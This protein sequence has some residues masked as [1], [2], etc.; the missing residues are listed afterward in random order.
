MLELSNA[1]AEVDRAYHVAQ[2]TY[3]RR[4]A[5]K[6][7]VA[8]TKAAYESDKAPLDLYLEAQRRN[9][10]AESEF[11]RRPG[12]IRPGDQEL[13]ITRKARC[14]TTTKSISRKVLAGQ[15]VSR[16]GQSA[17]FALAAPCPQLHFPPTTPVSQGTEP[18]YRVPPPVGPLPG[19]RAARAQC[20]RAGLRKCRPIRRQTACR[21]RPGHAPLGPRRPPAPSWP[22]RQFS[23]AHRRGGRSPSCRRPGRR[24]WTS[25]RTPLLPARMFR[26]RS[27]RVRRREMWP[28]RG[29]PRPWWNSP[30]FLPP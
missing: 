12:R 14:S 18:H 16:R 25:R 7:D 17:A 30:A 27:R 5:A 26:Q 19:G 10:D 28:R 24:R 2:T 29:L 8:S 4:M 22:N 6:T 20:R 11:L 13:C 9:A 3:N 23:F 21:R 1:V 15:S